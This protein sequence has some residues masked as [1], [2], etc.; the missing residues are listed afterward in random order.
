MLHCSRTGRCSTVTG[1]GKE[2]K[3]DA[4]LGGGKDKLEFSFLEQQISCQRLLVMPDN[5]N[6]WAFSLSASLR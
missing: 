2:C 6:N 4:M 3:D 5:I 1:W